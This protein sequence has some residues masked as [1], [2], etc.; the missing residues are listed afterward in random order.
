MSALISGVSSD[1]VLVATGTYSTDVCDRAQ[2]L[3]PLPAIPAVIAAGGRGRP[4]D[5]SL[6]VDVSTSYCRNRRRRLCSAVPS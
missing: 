5:N 1:H 3:F 2:K 6:S 4:K